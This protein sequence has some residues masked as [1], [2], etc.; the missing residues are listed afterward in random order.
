MAQALLFGKNSLPKHLNRTFESLQMAFLIHGHYI[1]AVTNF[2]DFAA[3]LVI[4]WY[5]EHLMRPYF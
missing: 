5:V 3:D 4:P 2:G 1:V